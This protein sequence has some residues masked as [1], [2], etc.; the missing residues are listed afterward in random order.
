MSDG[1]AA[2]DT[3]AIAS[4][5]TMATV[6]IEPV[7]AQVTIPENETLLS[8]LLAQK[9]TIQQECGRRGMC[10]TCHVQV[11]SGGD[12]LTP[13]AG[14]EKRTLSMLPNCDKNS[15]LSCQA[16]VLGSGDITVEVPDGMY[17]SVEDDIET[18]VGRRAQED[19]LHPLS[20]KI[21]VEE[22]KLITRTVAQELQSVQLEIGRLLAE[23]D[24]VG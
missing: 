3:L 11:L 17:L 7:N 12:N 1:R 10:A 19:I 4:N 6:T 20:G 18:L 2:T 16:R 13:V 9:L 8:G 24:S 22:Y 14:R 23:T 21:M 15:R 5:Q